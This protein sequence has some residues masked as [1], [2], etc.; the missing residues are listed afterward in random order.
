[1]VKVFNKD[2]E[3]KEIVNGK[4]LISSKAETFSNIDKQEGIKNW[5]KK[6]INLSDKLNKNY[7][8]YR[9]K[10]ICEAELGFYVSPYDIKYAMCMLDIKS[11]RGSSTRFIKRPDE[12]ESYYTTVDYDYYIEDVI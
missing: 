4:I 6:R 8:S 5:I 2:L 12:Q 11:R 1:M 9:L 7:G 3:I 10:D